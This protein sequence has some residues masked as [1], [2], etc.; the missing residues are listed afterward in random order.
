M[1]VRAEVADLLGGSSKGVVPGKVRS[2]VVGTV[3]VVVE[4]NEA[5][6][7]GGLGT[8]SRSLARGSLG[9]GRG[10][11]LVSGLRR[12]RGGSRLLLLDGSVGGGCS[13]GW[14]LLLNRRVGGS[15]LLS[16]RWGSSLGEGGGPCVSPGPAVLA[17]LVAVVGARGRRRGS[18]GVG[19]RGVTCSDSDVLGGVD[20][21]GLV[22]NVTLL[23]RD[24]ESADGECGS[25]NGRAH[26][27]RWLRVCL[28]V[29]EFC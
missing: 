23:K 20:D 4:L 1:L 29:V 16:G 19:R 12:L 8:G 26:L 13:V 3:D 2:R 18:R 22:D 28:V 11:L 27:D 21:V 24:R 17:L 6:V 15:L 9:G 10:R 5:L 25:N 14:G 7:V